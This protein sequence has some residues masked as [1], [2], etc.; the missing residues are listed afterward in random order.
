MSYGATA[1]RMV[2][3]K[4]K[5]SLLFLIL[6]GTLLAGCIRVTCQTSLPD[7]VVVEAG[8]ED[9]NENVI[10]GAIDVREQFHLWWT[11]K[12]IG[13]R[14]ASRF[15]TWFY[16]PKNDIKFLNARS[17]WYQYSDHVNFKGDERGILDPGQSQ[18]WYMTVPCYFIEAGTYNFRVVAN[19]D[20]GGGYRIVKESNYDNNEYSFTVN[21]GTSAASTSSTSVYTTTHTSVVVSTTHKVT[22]TEQIT[23][24]TI[25]ISS[26][27]ASLNMYY[28]AIIAVV[29]VVVASFFL[30]RVRS[31]S[32]PS[33]KETQPSSSNLKYC[34]SCGKE[35]ETDA[36]FCN[37]CGAKQ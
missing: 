16:M 35:L 26:S 32:R 22:T 24:E 19:P 20:S 28:I 17:Y 4:A 11:V 27:P 6:S 33:T 34:N 14:Q 15:D 13:D 2:S 18:S 10:N 12:N 1:L 23:T 3:T 9:L 36:Q 37:R 25:P 8:I 31:S 29:A 30:M 21:V 7:V 5:T